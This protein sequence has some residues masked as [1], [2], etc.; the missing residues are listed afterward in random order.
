MNTTLAAL[1]YLGIIVPTVITITVFLG[2]L[3]CLYKRN[4]RKKMMR[5]SRRALPPPPGGLDKSK[6][7]NRSCE[8]FDKW[9]QHSDDSAIDVEEAETSL[10]EKLA[11]GGIILE[12]KALQS[13][14]HSYENE[15][16]QLT[17]EAEIHKGRRGSDL[18]RKGYYPSHEK[19][20]EEIHSQVKIYEKMSDVQR[21][22]LQLQQKG[23]NSEKHLVAAA[24]K[25]LQPEERDTIRYTSTSKLVPGAQ[26]TTSNQLD[27]ASNY[28]SYS[29]S[30]YEQQSQ[31]LSNSIYRSRYEPPPTSWQPNIAVSCSSNTDN[32]S[33]MESSQ[34]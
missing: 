9:S 24:I 21:V 26:P 12:A 6:N 13:S 15:G 3:F 31:E 17:T 5:L 11:A 20:N 1:F 14:K 29:P 23:E 25:S 33:S 22:A 2:F 28:A 10:D 30:W 32:Y 8:K 18:L 19:L 34:V 16:L 27:V 4:L 7:N